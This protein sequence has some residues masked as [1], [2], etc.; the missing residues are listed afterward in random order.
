MRTPRHKWESPDMTRGIVTG[1]VV[2]AAVWGLLV[3]NA[4]VQLPGPRGCVVADY[5][6]RQSTAYWCGGEVRWGSLP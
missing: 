6:H 4:L 3:A 5:L 1:V 2:V